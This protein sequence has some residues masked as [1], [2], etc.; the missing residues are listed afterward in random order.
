MFVYL[1]LFIASDMVDF[2]KTGHIYH[3]HSYSIYRTYILSFYKRINYLAES[4]I[5]FYHDQFFT[6]LILKVLAH[7]ML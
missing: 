3:F 4:L 6:L 1:K 2:P 7:S 5:D